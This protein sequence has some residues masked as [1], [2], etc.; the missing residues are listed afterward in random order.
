M[1]V[2]REYCY[3]IYEGSE[4]DPGENQDDVLVEDVDEGKE[5]K[6]PRLGR[7]RRVRTQTTT[8]YVL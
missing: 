6:S 5:E 3:S 1:M 8:G 2:K 7:G 4:A